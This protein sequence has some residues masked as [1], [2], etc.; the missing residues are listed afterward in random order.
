MLN[1]KPA[2]SLSSFT[3]IK[4]LVTKR[5]K[6]D[7]VVERCMNL[8]PVIQSEITQKNGTDE[9]IFWAGIEMQI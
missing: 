4:R 7:S 8:E 1:F 2:I 9:H 5:N 3:F 6:L